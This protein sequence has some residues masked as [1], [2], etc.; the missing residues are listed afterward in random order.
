M[1]G[2][3]TALVL[4]SI[5]RHSSAT[6]IPRLETLTGGATLPFQESGEGNKEKE[7]GNEV[8]LFS[9]SLETNTKKWINSMRSHE[10]YCQRVKD[11]L[12]RQN[13]QE[14]LTLLEPIHREKEKDIHSKASNHSCSSG[15][16]KYSLHV[17]DDK[18]DEK[19]NDGRVD[20]RSGD[21]NKLPRVL[22]VDDTI[23]NRKMLCR[24]L[25]SRCSI[26]EQADDGQKA[27]DLVK[28]SM[29]DSDSSSKTSAQFDL[30]LMDFM[31]PVMDGPTAIKEIRRLGYKGLIF[32]LTGNVLDSDKDL[33][34]TNGANFVLFKPFSMEA[35][36]H[37]ML[38]HKMASSNSSPAI[39]EPT[40]FYSDGRAKGDSDVKK[41]VGLSKS[42]AKFGYLSTWKYPP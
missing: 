20:S 12:P 24:V 25:K 34:L 33:M 9:A 8:E 36:D 11:P 14:I 10:Q 17:S 2:W 5:S 16:G 19:K 22:V 3:S 18:M 29:V 27:V 26:L 23:S 28:E 6:V 21:T 39:A 7:K 31:M 38:E 35:F 4:P 41:G 15:D 13:H 40:H 42:V 32:G 37:A 30:I 1:N